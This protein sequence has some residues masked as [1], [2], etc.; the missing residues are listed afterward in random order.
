MERTTGSA[1]RRR[2]PTALALC[3]SVLSSVGAVP[4]LAQVR[5][6][7]E[8]VAGAR[9]DGNYLQSDAVAGE[10]EA[11][12][13]D[14]SIG[15]IGLLLALSHQRQRS[16]LALVYNP[17]YEQSLDDSELSAVSHRLDLS[18]E[19]RLTRRSTLSLRER[20]LSSPNLDLGYVV[21]PEVVS[22]A[23]RGDQLTHH[24][25][26]GNSYDLTR[27]VAWLVDA[28]HGIRDFEDP[29]L[30]DSTTLG[31]STGVRWRL[32]EDRSFDLTAGARRF[33]FDGDGALDGLA[34]R[35]N[36]RVD[37]L[38]ATAAF[39]TRLGRDVRLR[40]EGGAWAVEDEQPERIVVP[41]P[42]DP[43][44]PVAPRSTDGDGERTGW[45][46][47]FTLSRDARLAAWSLGYRHDLSAGVG[48][49]R[50]TEVDT[51]FAGLGLDLGRR[52]TLGF[53]GSASQSRDLED[54]TVFDDERR[55]NELATGSVRLGWQLADLLRVTAGYSRVW[56]ES[57]IATLDD[58]SYDRYFLNLAVR[59]WSRGE[60][61]QAP[62]RPVE[63][64]SDEEP[65]V[66]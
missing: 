10:A 40:L 3:L 49:G 15:M 8:A 31:A 58:L 27:R 60:T 1:R 65:D 35:D 9:S 25:S 28:E 64:R 36:R 38:E 39:D 66:E 11:E 34:F 33:E 22:V 5:V 48:V 43:D 32:T 61:P 45:R 51:A 46:G 7:V 53:D 55:L 14:Q 29:A 52:V 63:T 37:S 21:D 62:G 54:A 17:W 4:G 57:E 47:G 16:E 13:L 30:F 44:G 2:R 24:F 41:D 23:R 20:L 59:L 50:I 18:Y 42:G 56:Q 26:A 12:Q 19:G 6:V